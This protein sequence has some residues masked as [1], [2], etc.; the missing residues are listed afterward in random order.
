MVLTHT[1][2]GKARLAME[3][4]RRAGATILS[5][6]SMKVYRHMEIGTAKPSAAARAACD[7]RGLDLVDPEQD[8]DTAR[9]VEEAERQI[10]SARSERRPILV[11]GGT[12]LY[13]KGLTEGLF[14][15]PGRDDALRA[16]LREEA[17]QRGL[18]E[19]HAELA[20]RASQKTP[21]SPISITAPTPTRRSNGA[22]VNTGS[23]FSGTAANV[24]VVGQPWPCSSWYIMCE[25]APRAEKT[26][27]RSR[28]APHGSAATPDSSASVISSW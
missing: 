25:S 5:C 24:I 6:D 11:S 3:V 23:E 12:A 10:A 18:A 13:I 16:E 22:Y 14:A 26:P 7:W 1:A 19:L 28:C 2:G 4:A 15:G 27:R 9:W 8:F 21:T 20:P 17:R